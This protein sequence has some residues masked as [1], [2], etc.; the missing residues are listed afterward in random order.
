MTIGC[1]APNLLPS[2]FVPHELG[3]ELLDSDKRLFAQ[4]HHI[5][6]VALWILDRHTHHGIKACEP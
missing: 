4:Q 2:F 3:D 6:L 1:G 5:P